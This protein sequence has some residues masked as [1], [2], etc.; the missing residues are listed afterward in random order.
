MTLLSASNR[1]DTRG[2][3]EE[4]FSVAMQQI[5]RSIARKPH[6]S[7]SHP[8]LFDCKEFSMANPT[9][10]LAAWQKAVLDATIACTQAT[11]ASA[12]QL[13]TLNLDAARK[14]LEQQA[15]STRELLSVSDP[16]QL[17]AMRAKLA[18]QGMQQSAAYANSIYEIV[19]QTQSH[20]SKLAE[21]QFSRLSQA[22]PQG[23]EPLAANAPGAEVAAAAW[24]S[25]MAASSALLDGLNRA[26]RQ[27]Q[28]LS[29][30]NIKAATA[31]MVR[32]TGKK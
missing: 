21:D 13:V 19:S 11:L 30:T 32:G 1:L 8:T 20:I 4:N 17:L 12:E 9:D 28:E 31:G 15:Q 23:A 18:Q 16:Q 6:L 25:S 10:T 27:F 26:A 22:M 24:K 5:R 7:P 3:E 2:M 29:E 14:A